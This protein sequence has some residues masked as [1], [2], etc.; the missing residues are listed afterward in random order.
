V[1][2]YSSWQMA[3]M[4]LPIVPAYL[5]AIYFSRK[6]LEAV[7]ADVGRDLLR[8]MTFVHEYLAGAVQINVLHCHTSFTRQAQD[9]LADIRRKQGRRIMSD[10]RLQGRAGVLALAG[11]VMVLFYGAWRVQNGALTLGTLV[12]CY[13]FFYRL[14]DPIG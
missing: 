10:A 9:I 4:L 11:T 5:F 13:S 6:E 14:L 3:V 12:L 1:I 8:W 7:T 2:S